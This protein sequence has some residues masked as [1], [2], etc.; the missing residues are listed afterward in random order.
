MTRKDAGT[1]TS[2]ANVFFSA[3]LHP[4]TIF[5]LFLLQYLQYLR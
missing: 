3:V 2:D 5:I 4:S 1:S